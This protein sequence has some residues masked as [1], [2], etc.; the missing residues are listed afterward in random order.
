MTADGCV[1]HL[2]PPER[3]LWEKIITG[4]SWPSAANQPGV[5]PPRQPGTPV[6]SLPIACNDLP[7]SNP[8][9]RAVCDLKLPSTKPRF[10]GS[11][12]HGRSTVKSSGKYRA[13]GAPKFFRQWQYA[14]IAPSL[15]LR[16]RWTPRIQASAS[17]ACVSLEIELHM[18]LFDRGDYPPA[19]RQLT[20]RI[21]RIRL[22]ASIAPD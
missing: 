4:S 9:R 12:L 17:A 7:T 20:D 5:P 3:R 21:Q 6:S 1:V 8:V 19:S 18:P 14:N 11:M 22:A 2:N 16:T 15:A 10:C 13:R